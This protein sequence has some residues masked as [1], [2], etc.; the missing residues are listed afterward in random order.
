MDKCSLWQR[1]R[2]VLRTV[3]KDLQQQLYHF[4]PVH[5]LIFLVYATLTAWCGYNVIFYMIRYLRF[6]TMIS[7]YEEPA[8]ITSFPGI[9]ICGPTIFTPQ[10]LAGLYRDCLDCFQLI[11]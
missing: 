8:N 5:G 6:Q 1:V 11:L 4:R 3:R 9:T 10:K 2:D 7:L